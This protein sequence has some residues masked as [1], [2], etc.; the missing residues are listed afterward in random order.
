METENKFSEYFQLELIY[1]T[2]R[3][4]FSSII[5]DKSLFLE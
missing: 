3:Q 2:D 4:N 5:Q 1:I